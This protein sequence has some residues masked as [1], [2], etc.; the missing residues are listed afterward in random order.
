MSDHKCVVGLILDGD[1]P[2]IPLVTL[3]KLKQHIEDTKA[4][5]KSFERMHIQGKRT[6]FTL[7]DYADRRRATDFVRF[8]FCPECGRKI[9]WKTIRVMRDG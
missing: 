7:R 5:N 3:D 9:D 6:E 1:Y 8:D 2:E 4:I